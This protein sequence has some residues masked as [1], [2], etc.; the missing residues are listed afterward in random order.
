ME[1]TIPSEEN[2]LF[3]G[4][5]RLNAKMLGLVLG[6]LLGLFICIMNNWLVIKGGDPVGPHLGLLS[7]FFIGYRLSFPG[8]IIGF[9]YGF[10]VGTF[11]GTMVGWIYNR[12]VDFRK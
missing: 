1:D 12:I 6:V 5:L 2:K 3:S 9:A 10:A 8:S 7:Q 4:I 11:S